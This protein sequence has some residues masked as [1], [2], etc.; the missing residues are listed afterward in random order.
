MGSVPY[1]MSKIAFFENLFICVLSVYETLSYLIS[2]VLILAV[3][4]FFSVQL[5]YPLWHIHVL[6]SRS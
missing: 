3:S 5:S 1:S 6:S 2:Y 4:V